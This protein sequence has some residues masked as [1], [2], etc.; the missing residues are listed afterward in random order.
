[1][2]CF[3]F[4]TI[5]FLR[6]SRA[7]SYWNRSTC[8]ISLAS[9]LLRPTFGAIQHQ[10]LLSRSWDSEERSN[11]SLKF[12]V[13]FYLKWDFLWP[14]SPQFVGK[15]IARLVCFIRERL[16]Y[17][18]VGIVDILH[19]NSTIPLR[20]RRKFPRDGALYIGFSGLIVVYSNVQGLLRL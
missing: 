10:N 4:L 16:C 8:Y 7:S 12:A 6:K 1:M 15:V 19:C 20:A 5:F 13:N 17:Q 11:R 9:S 18:R 14:T 3:F 2:R